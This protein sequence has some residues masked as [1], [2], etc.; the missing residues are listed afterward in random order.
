[1]TQLKISPSKCEYVN[2]FDVL[3]LYGLKQN[4]FIFRAKLGVGLL[5]G[6]YSVP[7]PPGSPVD[8]DPPGITPLMFKTLVGKGHPEFSTKKQQDVQEF[9][10]HILTLLE[11]H[12]MNHINPGECFK[13]E[14]EERFQCGQSKKVKYLT[15]SE[16]C[17]GLNIP[18]DAAI[19][20]ED[21]S[22]YFP[23]SLHV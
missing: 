15:R 23:D 18:M 22:I 17:L 11:R 3:T 5:S 1:M 4:S 19:N 2:V 8:A 9:L 6:K 16:V 13:F 7:P 10:L 14:V 12:N 21:V 20:K